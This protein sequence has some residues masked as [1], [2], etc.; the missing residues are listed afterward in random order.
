MNTLRAATRI[1]RALIMVA[2]LAAVVVGLP[3]GLWHFFGPPLPEH[4]P[5]YSDIK[6]WLDQAK[7]LPDE[8]A[9]RILDVA[10][11]GYWALFTWQVAI[12]L[13]GAVTDTIR[14]LRTHTTLPTVTH[15]NLAGRLLSTVAISIIAARGTISVASATTSASSPATM[16]QQSV[17]ASTTNTAVHVVAAGECLWDIAEHRLGDPQRWKEIYRANQHRVQS[18]G[19]VL[20]DPEVIRPGWIL[21]LPADAADAA[22]TH[23]VPTPATSASSS[24]TRPLIQAPEP[25][26]L[27]QAVPTTSAA[28]ETAT[29]DSSKPQQSRTRQTPSVVRRPVAIDL[30]TGGYVSLTLGAGLAAALVAARVRSRIN[31]RRRDSDE[32]HPPTQRLGEPEATL[33][34]AAAMI[35]Y[36]NDDETDPYIDTPAGT[37]PVPHALAPLRAPIAVYLGNRHGQPI[38]LSSVAAGGLGLIGDG[39]QDA[40]RAALASALA[41]GGFLVSANVYTVIT[42]TDDLHALAG[43]RLSGRIADRLIVCDTLAEALTEASGDSADTGRPLLVATVASASAIDQGFENVEA[44]ML[45]CRDAASVAAID[46]AGSITATGAA[47]P[48]L[49]GAQSYRISFEE[50]RALLDRLLA[51]APPAYPESVA[52]IESDPAL[53]AQRHKEQDDGPPGDVPTADPEAL[54]QVTAPPV[55]HQASGVIPAAPEASLTVNILGPLQVNAAGRDAT[56]AFRPL[57]AAVLILLA[58]NPRGITRTAL[59]CELWPEPNLDPDARAKRFKATLS[60]T[61]TALAEAYGG[62]A[63]HIVEARPARLLTLN[64]SLITCD[65]WRFDQLLDDAQPSHGLE[66]TTRLAALLEAIAL[67]RG[68]VAHGHEHSGDRGDDEA[69]LAGHRETHLRRLVDAHADAAA[70]LR[71]TDPDHAIAVLEKA[72]ELEPWNNRLTEQVIKIHVEHGQHHAAARRYAALNEHLALLGMKPSTDIINLM[73][74]AQSP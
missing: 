4:L 56:A 3:W 61:R 67:H 7:L 44:V 55:P 68:P 65:A 35:G 18:D 51:A 37:V 26:H 70:L 22:P 5:A 46:T 13:P 15:A 20:T 58:L 32:P 74:T 8:A 24:G 72:C 16:T 53:P 28:P 62:K 63:D 17:T 66:P 1:M 49:D 31:A 2:L 64:R 42:T 39:A 10:A 71:D 25:E 11:W 34:K 23:T 52:P 29:P 73:E 47:G 41:A 9:I 45:G 50:A 59:A 43:H 33:L 48:V 14:A 69:W 30:P 27:R 40:A 57:T 54:R 60:H 6:T 36:G 19:L 12:Q 38:P 21:V